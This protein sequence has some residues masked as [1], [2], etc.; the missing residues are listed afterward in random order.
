MDFIT[1]LLVSEGFNAIL[2]VIDRLTKLR[3]YIPCNATE[4]LEELAR[5]FI[6]YI[7][8]YHGL[9]ESIVSDRGA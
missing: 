2:A 8:K 3:Y 6:K 1:H 5:L 7:A 4:G 9:P